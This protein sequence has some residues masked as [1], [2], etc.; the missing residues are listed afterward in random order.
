MFQIPLTKFC[1]LKLNRQLIAAF[2][3]ANQ[4]RF[5]DFLR[6]TISDKKMQITW[7][8]TIWHKG[9]HNAFTDLCEH[10]GK[11]LCC[12]REAQNHISADGIIR[13]L[14]LSV[15]GNIEEVQRLNIPQ[16]DLRDPKLSI[17]SDGK[18]L[19]I[20][21][22]RHTKGDNKTLFGQAVSWV[23]S[24][25]R[26]WSSP[27]YFAAKNWWLWRIRWHN[28][29]ALGFAYNRSQQALNL[30]QGDP[31]RTFNL[32]QPG[33]LSLEKHGKGYPN[34][35][36][37]VFAQDDTAY[38]LIRRDADSCTAQL[39]KAK[40]PY[41]KWQWT[42]L[43]EYI[44]GPVMLDNGPGKALVAGRIWQNTEPKTA[45]FE[46]DLYRPKLTLKLILPSAGDSSYPGLVRQ[47][48][49]LFVSYYSS[50]MDHKSNIYLAKIKLSETD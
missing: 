1:R 3:F 8:K 41:K 13:V 38:A 14:K 4:L 19:L 11:F 26:S 28:G 16:A 31:R 17:T 15:D 33:V 47:G 36:D 32:I 2:A 43:K 24:D 46:L 21:Y 40:P 34:E 7:L 9:K 29:Q 39:G 22:A 10:K 49:N 18:L 42:D 5:N 37:I 6:Q 27:R 25:G 45:L 44:G 20:A 35:S 23:S 12:F 30:Y 50:H 48:N